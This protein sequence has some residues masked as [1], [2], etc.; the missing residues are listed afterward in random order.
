MSAIVRPSFYRHIAIA[1]VLFTI[2]GFSRTYYLRFLYDLPPLETLVHLHGVI[3][4]A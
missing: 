1:L 2:I 4:T 3:F